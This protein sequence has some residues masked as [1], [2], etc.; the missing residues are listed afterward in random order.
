MCGENIQ[1]A[2][3]TVSACINNMG[4]GYGD[5]AV[6]FAGL[7]DTGKWLMC[8]AMLLGRL[9]VFP[10]LVMFSRTYWR[11]KLPWQGAHA[12]HTCSAHPLEG[13]SMPS[14]L[15]QYHINVCQRSR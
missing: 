5:T 11:F 3:G 9:E 7:T 12:Y 8:A 13:F 10:I 4:I 2:F 1:T 14:E 15:H 6:N